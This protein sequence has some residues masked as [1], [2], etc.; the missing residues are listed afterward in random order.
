ML[1]RSLRLS[2]LLPHRTTPLPPRPLSPHFV[3]LIL[4]SSLSSSSHL[5]FSFL[6]L[7]LYPS[8]S[9]LLLFPMPIVEDNKQ[10]VLIADDDLLQDTPCAC[11]WCS[12]ASG[13]VL[14]EEEGKKERKGDVLLETMTP[15]VCQLRFRPQHQLTDQRRRQQRKGWREGM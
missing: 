10:T 3:F 13:S 9:S 1:P 12:A 7:F 11:I 6:H 4:T 15:A 5:S 14:P 2:F 8:S